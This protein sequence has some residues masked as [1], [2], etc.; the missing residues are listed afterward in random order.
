[1][2]ALEQELVQVALQEE[3]LQYEAFNAD[4]AWGVGNLIRMHAIARSI[5]MSIEISIAELI[6]FSCVTNG[7]SAYDTEVLRRKRNVVAQFGQS[8]HRV[9]LQLQKDGCSLS[10]CGL[11][12]KHYTVRGGGFPLTL[13]GTGCIGSVVASGP[14]GIVDHTIVV[15][16]L[17]SM[18]GLDV[19]SWRPTI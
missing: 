10:E 13:K 15:D 6:V 5:A 2:T 17:A 7:S 1:M 16:A 18:L 8:S 19:K 4:V 9:G 11:S 12:P 14:D 3:T